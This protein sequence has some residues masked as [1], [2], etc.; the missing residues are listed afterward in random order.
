MKG[1]LS[2][3]IRTLILLALF[4][5]S[6]LAFA[7][8]KTETESTVAPFIGIRYWHHDEGLFVTGV[9]PNTPA[10]N[11]ELQ[12]GD[13]VMAVDGE[14]IQVE[15]VREVVWKHDIGSTVSL[16]IVRNDRTFEQDL[17]LVAR[18]ADLFENPDY[19]MPL[20]LASV[21]LYVGQCDDKLLVI[22]ALSDSEVA[23][24]GFHIYDQ[25]IEI[26]GDVVSTIGEADAAV[27]NLSEGDQLSFTVLRG[28]REMMIKVIV[29]DQRRR[30]PR[31]RR[32]RRPHPRIEVERAYVSDNIELG[33]GDG[34]VVVSVLNPAH[35]LYAAGLRQFDLIVEANGTSVEEAADLYSGDTIALTV[36][37]VNS[38]LN[39]DVPVSIAPLL[40]YGDVE[41]VEQDRSQWLDLHEKQVTLG[42]RYWQLEPDSPYF[43][44]SDVTQ[45]ALVA[46]V[47]EGLPAAK[48][49]V[50]EG[51]IIVAV[52]GEPVTLEI[53][54]RNRI[55]FHEPG[56]QVTLDILRAGEIVQIDVVLRVAS[57]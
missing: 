10:A 26:D 36:E 3:C 27:S 22:G 29:E 11:L 33:Y 5:T 9:I 45:G 52:A 44:G 21:G 39:F 25:I 41:P 35:D 54:L 17:T 57:K 48:V 19:A 32:P 28:E 2:I 18:P 38:R 37:R 49:G 43:E 55:Y 24:A 13:I 7:Q 31:H 46:E 53:D 6:A 20:D 14:A 1:M 40:M 42:V 51:D 30:D 47:I 4:M 56:E 8:E 50:Q 12:A 15:T 34:F 23:T 16:A